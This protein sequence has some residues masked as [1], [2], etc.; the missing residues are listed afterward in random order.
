MK[1]PPHPT[2][3][4]PPEAPSPEQAIAWARAQVGVCEQPV[5][6]SRG[7]IVDAWQAEYGLVGESWCGVFLGM[8][9][10]AGGIVV[11]REVVWLPSV[12][13]WARH[14]NYDFSLDGWDSRRAGDIVLFAFDSS[15]PEAQHGGLL[16]EDR[17][18]TVEGNTT[19]GPGGMQGHGGHVALKRRGPDGVVACVRPPWPGGGSLTVLGHSGCA[20]RL[21]SGSE[22]AADRHTSA[23]R[24]SPKEVILFW[25]VATTLALAAGVACSVIVTWFRIERAGRQVVSSAGDAIVVFGAQAVDGQPCPELEARLRFA[26]HLYGAARAPLILCTGG[27]AGPQSEPRIMRNVLV[28]WGVPSSDILIDEQGSSTRKS[29]AAAKRLPAGPRRRVLLVSSPY[30][31]YRIGGEARRQ[32]LAAVGCPAPA[33]PVMRHSSSRSRQMLREVVA[34]WW[35]RVQGRPQSQLPSW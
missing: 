14:G 19:I 23:R 30:H 17:A 3:P 15:G 10:R 33:T 24:G 18:T 9:L 13:G 31:M 6:S 34:T 20:I 12:L 28:M 21:R 26:A 5:G 11:P 32:G 2:I 16:L 7:P 29:I 22:L 35:Y 4:T 25:F 1:P 8:A 27:H